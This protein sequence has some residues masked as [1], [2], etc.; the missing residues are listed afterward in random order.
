MEWDFSPDEV[1]T[2]EIPY[3]IYDF[4][5]DLWTEVKDETDVQG[6][7]FFFW[8]IY[9]LAIGYSTR[10]LAEI[11][12]KRNDLSS[13]ETR[14]QLHRFKMLESVY[15]EEIN[16]FRGIVKRQLVEYRQQGIEFFD[17]KKMADYIKHWIDQSV[18]SH[19]VA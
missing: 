2:G 7:E 10:Q 6:F 1:V 5:E 11:F 13:E 12:R 18:K 3:N 16:M 14:E 9:H 19:S 15:E 17:E 8:V 4:R